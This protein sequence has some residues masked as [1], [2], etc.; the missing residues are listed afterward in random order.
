MAD[1]LVDTEMSPRDFFARGIQLNLTYWQNFI[2]C[3]DNYVTLDS[4]RPQIVRAI[5]FG[6][7]QP[8]SWALTYRL[9]ITFSPYMEKR[10]PG[11]QWNAILLQAL[12]VAQQMTDLAAEINL[13]IIMA[14]LL[15]QQGAFTQAIQFYR[16]ILRLSKQGKDTFNEARAYTNLGYLYIEYDRWWRAAVLCCHALTLFDQLDNDYGR[17]HTQNHLGVL[18]TRQRAWH[19]AQR[20]LSQACK[21]WRTI[22]DAPG[23]LFGLINLGLLHNEMECPNEALVH[24]KE[25][26]V[27]AEQL[28]HEAQI[29][30]IYIN[31]GIAYRLMGIAA[32]AEAYAHKAEQLHQK[33]SNLLGIGLAWDNQGLACLDQ[34]KWIVA[35]K[36]FEDALHLWQQLKNKHNMIRTQ[37]YLVELELAQTNVAQALLCLDE[38]ETL[39]LQNGWFGQYPALQE[40]WHK[41]R[42]SSVV[43][44]NQPTVTS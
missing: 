35:K 13:S 12:V 39:N 27:L 28:G 19:D 21:T 25:A 10:N 1:K 18:C 15:R 29:A 2:D 30:A 41:H 20:Y 36:H 42:H 23:L 38:L 11:Q 37:L 9:L 16:K 33:F 5:A 34:K 26:L 31:I 22:G 32:K 24:L 40:L 6:L 44:D 4:V 3:N 8:K 43:R 14:R 7:E 17:A